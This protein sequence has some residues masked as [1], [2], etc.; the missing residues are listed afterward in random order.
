MD[1]KKQNH[2][3]YNGRT[4]FVLCCMMLCIMFCMMTVTGCGNDKQENVVSTVGETDTSKQDTVI[5]N[6]VYIM[7]YMLNDDSWETEIDAQ[8]TT[9]SAELEEVKVYLE[10]YKQM[11][12][13]NVQEDFNF[14]LN[15]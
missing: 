8:I 9:N 6:G 7:L 13:S 5:E 4:M 14:G 3:R 11:L 12:S 2:Q 15:G 1:K 10:S